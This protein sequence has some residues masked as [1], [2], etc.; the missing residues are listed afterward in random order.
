MSK[1]TASAL[2]LI[3]GTP[4]LKADRYADKAG[5]KDATI[6]TKLE[7]LNPAGSVKDRIALAMIEDAEKKGQL[8][9]GSTIIEPTSGNT[10]I[11]LAAV[12]TAKGYRAILTLPDTMSVERRNLLKAY[13]AELVLTEGAK[14]MKGA[15]AKADELAKEID[16]AVILGQFVNPANPAVHKATTGPEIWDQTDGKVDIFVA[17]VGTGGTLTG[18]G[19]YLKEQNPDVKIVAVEPATSP[20]LSTGTAGAHKIQGIGAGFVPDTLN[21]KIYDEVITIENE[22]AFT[23]GRAFAHSEGIL[24]G[25]SSGAALKTATILAERP[26]NKGKTNNVDKSYVQKI[27][28]EKSDRRSSPSLYATYDR[29]SGD[30]EYE[31]EKGNVTKHNTDKQ[32]LNVIGGTQWKVAGD[33]LEWTTKVE[34]E[35]DYVIGIKGRQG[36]NRGYIANR[37]LYIDGE[38]PFKEVASLQF[39]YSNVWEM[40]CLQN[41]KGEAYKFHLTAGEHKI[42]LK[43]TLGE[44][45]EYLSQLSESVYRMNQYYRQILV[46]TGTEPD[47]FRDY[48]IEKVYPDIIKAMGDESKILYRLVDEVTAYTGERGGE[49]AVAQTLAAQMEEFVDRP[50]KIPQTLSNFKENVSSLGTSINNLSA[51]AMDIDYIVLAG[52]KSSIEEVNEGSFDRIVHECTL[53]INSFRSDSSALGNVYD[54]DDP[55]VIDVWITAGRDQS[56]ILKNM[57]DQQFTPTS[58]EKYGKEIK[59]NVKLIDAA[60]SANTV[61]NSAGAV[62]AMLPAVMSGNGPDVALCISQTEPV[63]YALRG[64]TVDLTQFSDYKD[65]LSE[66]QA[67]SYESYWLKDKSGHKGLYGLPETENYNVLFYR[68]DI[69]EE[70]GIDATQI[71]TWDDVIKVLPKLQ[72]NSMSFAIPSVERKI[73]NASNPD[74]ANYYAQLV[75]RGGSLYRDDGIET[76]IGST[77]GIQAFEFY[78]KLFTNYKLVKQYDFANRFRSGEMPIGVADYSTFNTL[79]VFAPEIKGLWNFGMVPGVKQED[80]SINRSVQSWG[81]ASMMLKG[82]EQRG[83]K[84][85]AWDFL[86]WWAS[87]DTQATYA[88]ELEAVMGAA[89]R[90]ATANKETFKTLSWSSKESTVLDEQHKWAFGI[91]QVAGGY[92]TERHITNAIRKVMNNNED[93][94]ETILDYVITIN[95]ELSNK[96]EE[97]GLKTL[98]QEEKETKQK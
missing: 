60:A 11:G 40:L 73:N 38:V 79:S 80:G 76:T 23:E 85:I 1:I 20:V 27:Q 66:Y 24:V 61:T 50:D 2:E 49:I 53:F 82:A 84:E 8:K 44:L 81:T 21:T 31:D 71:N 10:G 3:G 62:N 28:G 88:R 41:D 64:A 43:I 6:L 57:V 94:R 90:Y 78:T 54:S 4:L 14:G 5:V 51:T 42:R 30:T 15:I 19:E 75:Q 9:P 56:N 98:E 26:E 70:L 39:T 65:V 87:A 48:Q 13:G 45:G 72:K 22:D 25:I 83:K 91:P 36:Y 69:M 97:F 47:E 12:A 32:V 58:K 59:V 89:A 29:T 33:W 96:R 92:Y 52:D 86:K 17:G 93:P 34:K 16:G 74:L 35:G 7:Y 37:S 77:E 46:L 67:S 68:T 18:V 55:D 63:N 95:K